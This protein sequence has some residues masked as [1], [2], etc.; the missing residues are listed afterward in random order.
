MTNT[1]ND[2]ARNA[3]M[4][5]AL[6]LAAALGLVAGLALYFTGQEGA[7]RLVWTITVLP[8]LI[9]LCVDILRSL[10]RG[11]VGLDI[12][13]ALSM[14]TALGFGETLAAAVVA[15]MYTGGNV[16]ES[17]AEGRARRDMHALLSRVPRMAYRYAA[18]ALEDVPLDDIA[19]ADRL[20]IRQGDVVPVDGTVASKT[21]YLD[22]SALTG[23]SLP[24]RL[25]CEAE[26]MSGAT[27][28]GEPFDLI[29]A[30]RASQSTYAGIVR[31]VEQAQRSK[32]PMARLADRWSLG[33][34]AVTV[35]IA[36]AAWGLTGDP[37]RAVAVLVVATPC[38]LI[39]AVP[40]ALVAGL[41]RAA[42]FGVLI[43]GGGPLEAMARI[44][45]LILDKTGTL[46]DG[47]PQ[48]VSIHRSGD[49]SEEDILRYAASLDQASKHPVA[50]AIVAAA[51]ARGMALSVPSEVT[52]VAGS[53]V[54]G[55]VD[56][57]KVVVGGNDLV[58][59]RAAQAAEDMPALE[60]GAVLV[61]VAIDG[62]LAGHLVMA[63]P[64]RLGTASMLAGLREQGV[65][66]ILL[67]TGDRAAVADHVTEGLDMD[68]VR[69]GLTPDQKVLLVLSER[70]NGP[71]M[72]VGDGVNDA[73]ALAAA[74]VGVAM[75]ARGAAASAEAADV[76]L[77]VDRVD[78]LGPGIEIARRSRHIAMESVV[79][80]I[81]LSVAGMIAA[82][83]GYLT[84]VQGAVL[85]EVID[86]AVILNALRALRIVPKD[87]LSPQP[88]TD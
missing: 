15:V 88:S 66:R 5:K 75:G 85:Q 46:T 48:I 53:G 64:L 58:A 1:R 14:S 39:L 26:V 72:M 29:A 27:N 61:A 76:V 47:R 56:G 45:T 13:A 17:F 69:A 35:V 77:L 33:F 82:G 11:E 65:A 84:P 31:L 80:G 50:Q 60:A 43:K 78:R 24:V 19:P 37:I 21:A 59:G 86:V 16:L 38:P 18:G 22:S 73:P 87:G 71:V 49:A 4:K 7:S 51:K 8:V 9:A 57:R 34:L 42:R 68:G 2:A 6:F 44:H 74:T 63:D 28:A 36:L 3:R 83:F 67:A 32:A 30:R 41:S 23:E 40:V 10:M 12:V 52:E 25:A 55:T 70:Q 79:V 54:E 62:R 81:G 20:L